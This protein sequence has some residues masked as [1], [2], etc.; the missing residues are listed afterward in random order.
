MD[1]IGSNWFTLVQISLN[2]FKSDKI[3]SNWI[4]SDQ[5]GLNWFKVEQIRLIGPNQTKLDQTI[6][7]NQF[8]S[9]L[10]GSKQK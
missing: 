3:D 2:W 6:L 8:K 10:I 4:K 5:V 9:D 1:Q 7:N